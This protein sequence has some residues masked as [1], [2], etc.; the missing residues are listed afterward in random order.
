MFKA[1]VDVHCLSEL[2]DF[3]QVRVIDMRVDAKETLKDLSDRCREILWECDAELGWKERF[4]VDLGLDP[5]D[6]FDVRA[7]LEAYI[8]EISLRASM[9]RQRRMQE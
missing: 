5:A 1:G 9:G 2:L 7:K 4:V 3:I 6:D 8:N